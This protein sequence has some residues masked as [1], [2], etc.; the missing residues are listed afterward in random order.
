MKIHDAFL[1]RFSDGKKRLLPANYCTF[2]AI[3][4]QIEHYFQKMLYVTAFMYPIL[5]EYFNTKVLSF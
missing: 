3:L 5:T 1:R 4:K 2:S